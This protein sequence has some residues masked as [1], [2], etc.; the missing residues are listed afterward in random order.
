M[1]RHVPEHVPSGGAWRPRTHRYDGRDRRCK[2][3]GLHGRGV[4]RVSAEG[5]HCRSRWPKANTA[6]VENRR[7]GIAEAESGKTCLARS[8]RVPDFSRGESATVSRQIDSLPPGR[9]GE[10]CRQNGRRAKSAIP[11][12]GESAAVS[13]QIDSLPPQEYNI[14]VADAIYEISW[15]NRKLLN[16][17]KTL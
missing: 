2:P 14:A 9:T 15:S 6:E 4:N 3:S 10:G 5:K 17:H 8:G 13:R 7:I 1:F 16:L 12:P 11:P